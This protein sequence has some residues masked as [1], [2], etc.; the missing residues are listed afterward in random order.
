MAGKFMRRNAIIDT[1]KSEE[2]TNAFQKREGLTQHPVHAT[3]CQCPD[4]N[5][6]AWHEIITERT[7]PTEEECEEIIKKN[8]K[9]KKQ[10]PNKAVKRDK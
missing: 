2:R 5:C 7:L 10:K 9:N 4:P 6:G 1:I 3:V 8:N